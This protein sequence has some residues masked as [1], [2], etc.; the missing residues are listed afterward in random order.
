LSDTATATQGDA[1]V[2]DRARLVRVRNGR[3]P[4]GRMRDSR[5]GRLSGGVRR[6]RKL[7]FDAEPF[8]A[9]LAGDSDIERAELLVVHPSMLYRWRAEGMTI[10][11]VDRYCDRLGLLPCEIWPDYCEQ[12]DAIYR[13]E[14]E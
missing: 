4:D 9:Q 7:R 10:D 1:L 14:G 2:D 12:I 8:I 11:T 13:E 3:E 5:H 6:V